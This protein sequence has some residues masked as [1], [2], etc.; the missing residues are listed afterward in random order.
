M[1][2]QSATSCH[3]LYSLT[4]NQSAMSCHRLYSLTLNQSATSCHRLYSLTLHQSATSCHILY[5]LTLHQSATSCHRRAPVLVDKGLRAV[6]GTNM[7]VSL[8]SS[9]IHFTK[10][11]IFQDA[12]THMGNVYIDV[13]VDLVKSRETRYVFI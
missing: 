4:S 12:P 9:Q 3:R 8:V 5:S 2:N 6:V 11:N 1:L 10:R 13:Y 7:F